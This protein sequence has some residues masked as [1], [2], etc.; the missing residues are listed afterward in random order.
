MPNRAASV[1]LTMTVELRQ[2]YVA[3]NYPIVIMVV[4]PSKE[5]VL[6]HLTQKIMMATIHIKES[7]Q[8]HIAIMLH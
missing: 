4:L 6:K 8:R 3:H 2:V 1:N 7:E 5:Y